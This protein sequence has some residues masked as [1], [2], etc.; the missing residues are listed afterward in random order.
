MSR[1]GQYAEGGQQMGELVCGELSLSSSLLL[2]LLTT[3]ARSPGVRGTRIMHEGWM[4]C[5]M[6]CAVMGP[7]AS[8]ILRSLLEGT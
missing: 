6:S 1:F 8:R 5:Q 2:H 4:L 7:G 3:S